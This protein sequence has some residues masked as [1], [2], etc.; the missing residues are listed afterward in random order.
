MVRAPYCFESYSVK[1]ASQGYL[2]IQLWCFHIDLSKC[3]WSLRQI[4]IFLYLFLHFCFKQGLGFKVVTASKRCTLGRTWNTFLKAKGCCQPGFAVKVIFSGTVLSTVFVH[5]C[6]AI[7]WGKALPC[8]CPRL[9]IEKNLTNANT[10]EHV[11]KIILAWNW[12]WP[13]LFFRRAKPGRRFPGLDQGSLA[14]PSCQFCSHDARGRREKIAFDL[15][16]FVCVWKD[17]EYLQKAV[18]GESACFGGGFFFFS[19]QVVAIKLRCVVNYYLFTGIYSP[20]SCFA[21][22]LSWG[23]TC[24]CSGSAWFPSQCKLSSHADECGC[25]LQ[26]CF[27]WLCMG[28]SLWK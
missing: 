8:Q 4:S 2:A 6:S 14:R 26:R 7:C 28:S 1:S 24:M 5:F 10:G 27:S 9:G 22:S 12:Q 11:F 25:Q 3:S 17:L 16:F 13:R 23:S 21:C 15:F 19:M 18:E 20:G